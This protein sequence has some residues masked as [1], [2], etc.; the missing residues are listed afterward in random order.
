MYNSDTDFLYPAR[1]TPFLR[2][3]R[4]ETWDKLI[5]FIMGEQSSD[6]EKAAFTLMMVRLGRCTDC[7][8]DSFRASQGCTQCAKLMIHRFKGDDTDLENLFKSAKK[9]LEKY[10]KSKETSR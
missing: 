4:G 8:A 9:D 2:G 6:L 3:C 10:Q 7:D 5:D 1:V